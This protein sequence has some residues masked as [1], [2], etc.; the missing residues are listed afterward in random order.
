MG[1]NAQAFPG[2]GGSEGTEG[3]TWRGGREGQH[4]NQRARGRRE[5]GS[6]PGAGVSAA[7][8]HLLPQPDSV[9]P[10]M[11]A[12]PRQR[13]LAPPAPQRGIP[14]AGHCGHSR[15]EGKPRLGTARPR[16]PRPCR[17]EPRRWRRGPGE[18]A[19]REKMAARRGRAGGPDTHVLLRAWL[20]R[21]PTLAEL[22]RR[23]MPAPGRSRGAAGGGF[24]GDVALCPGRRSFPPPLRGGG[25][26][27][28]LER[29]FC[30]ITA[31]HK[32]AETRREYRIELLGLHST[33][34][35]APCA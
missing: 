17:E 8:R 13:P 22:T 23:G 32:L 34:R 21:T 12:P 27:L 4:R 3:Y 33:P 29:R 2:Q 20:L 1:E 35:V 15:N 30:R 25:G 16:L 18:G 11:A 24:K 6:A 19:V 10:N 9:P 7:G 5:A 31:N 28:V 26:I 14:P